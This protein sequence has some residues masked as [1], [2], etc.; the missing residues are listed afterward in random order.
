M[1]SLQ[2]AAGR[3][4]HP[5]SAPAAA[6]RPLL[7]SAGQLWKG[8]R[9]RRSPPA[10]A[11]RACRTPAAAGLSAVG[12]QP[13]AGVACLPAGLGQG[14]ESSLEVQGGTARGGGA[15]AATAREATAAAL[16]APAALATPTA[17][18]AAATAAA[19]A[20]AALAT[21]TAEV[22]VRLRGRGGTGK[23]GL[24]GHA[25]LAAREAGGERGLRAW[26]QACV[27]KLPAVNAQHTVLHSWPGA[28]GR[29]QASLTLVGTP[30]QAGCCPG[31]TFLPL[32]SPPIGKHY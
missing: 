1:S 9:H 13:A 15:A 5:A 21:A 3:R 8:R 28:Q 6:A 29:P 32:S 23:A 27:S 14:R 20:A 22:G 11:P 10:A 17:L 18:A 25:R 24:S 30:E 16:A 12:C 19:A 7:S 4:Q 26:W 31:A 2:L